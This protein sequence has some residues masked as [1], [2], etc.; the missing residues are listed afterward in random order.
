MLWQLLLASHSLVVLSFWCIGL[1]RLFSNHN[2]QKR[3]IHVIF[4]NLCF[5]DNKAAAQEVEEKCCAGWSKSEVPSTFIKVCVHVSIIQNVG[6]YLA[7]QNDRE[8]TNFANM[9]SVNNKFLPRLIEAATSDHWESCKRHRKAL[10]H[11]DFSVLVISGPVS[12]HLLTFCRRFGM[13]TFDRHQLTTSWIL[14]RLLSEE[15]YLVILFYWDLDILG[16]SPIWIHLLSFIDC[17]T[18]IRCFNRR[19]TDIPSR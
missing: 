4:E 13:H 11:S 2:F 10:F 8:L 9:L 6:W 1:L 7:M 16:K 14:R 15:T 17:F 12:W 5:Q 19:W 18:R 3:Y